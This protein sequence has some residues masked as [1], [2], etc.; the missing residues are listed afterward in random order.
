MLNLKRFKR[1]QGYVPEY[2]TVNKRVTRLQLHQNKRQIM[3]VIIIFFTCHA[4]ECNIIAK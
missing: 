2:A 1:A 4:L 3:Q